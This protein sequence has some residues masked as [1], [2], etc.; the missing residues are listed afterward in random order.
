MNGSQVKQLAAAEV[1][2]SRGG[3]NWW[4]E[5]YDYFMKF[6]TAIYLYKLIVAGWFF[7]FSPS[8]SPVCAPITRIFHEGNR[9]VCVCV[10]GRPPNVDVQVIG[11]KASWGRRRLIV[12][13]F[14]GQKRERSD[15]GKIFINFWTAIK[16]QLPAA[17][18]AVE[19]L[20]ESD[21]SV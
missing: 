12:N 7:F 5:A 6:Y 20:K 13:N 19:Q 18:V 21:T 17:D 9:R 15:C 16:I 11:A 1:Q 2:L 8:D 4:G 3:D 14:V 10:R